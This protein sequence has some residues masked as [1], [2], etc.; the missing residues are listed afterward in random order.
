M[1]RSPRASATKGRAG[2]KARSTPSKNTGSSKKGAAEPMSRKRAASGRGAAKGAGASKGAAPKGITA[3]RTTTKSSGSRTSTGSKTTAKRT[4]ARSRGRKGPSQAESWANSVGSLLTSPLGREILA[5]VLDAASAV[6]R[7][8]R[9]GQQVTGAVN[10]IADTGSDIVST[11]ADVSTDVASGAMDAGITIASAMADMAETAAGSLAAMATGAV[12]DTVDARPEDDGSKSSR[13][14]RE[15][16]GARKGSA[17][18]N[19]SS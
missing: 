11:A 2:G 4:V 13:K 14:S 1:A 16:G 10:A 15:R 18:E 7:R 12:L 8:D 9:G 6:L 3:S 19:T 5:D 17:G